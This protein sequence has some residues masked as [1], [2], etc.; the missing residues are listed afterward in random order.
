M[1]FGFISFYC[2]Q[3]QRPRKGKL[4]DKKTKKAENR[5]ENKDFI[6]GVYIPVLSGYV[7]RDENFELHK[8]L[9]RCNVDIY[10]DSVVFRFPQ[11]G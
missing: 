7:N 8:G 1:D 6:W 4:H 5:P 2:R 10:G 9:W 11:K 3:A